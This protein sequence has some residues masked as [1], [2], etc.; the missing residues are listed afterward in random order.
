[1]SEHLEGMQDSM[2]LW[3]WSLTRVTHYGWLGNDGREGFQK[4]EGKLPQF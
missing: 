2:S 4:T 3:E 1:M